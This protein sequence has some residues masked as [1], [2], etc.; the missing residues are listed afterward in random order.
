MAL[1]TFVR[2]LIPVVLLGVGVACSHDAAGLR[3]RVAYPATLRLVPVLPAR[4]AAERA[5]SQAVDSINIAIT[6]DADDTLAIKGVAFPLG[7]DSVVVTI[8]VDLDSAT[9]VVTAQVDIL[10][11][12]QVVYRQVLH[13]TASV[14]SQFS[15]HGDTVPLVSAVWQQVVTQAQ[16]AL[17]GRVGFA[18]VYDA[19]QKE[20]VG[21][22]GATTAGPVGETWVLSGGQWNQLRIAGPAARVGHGMVY[23][24]GRGV[25]VLFGGATASGFTNDTWEFNAAT[26]T[27]IQVTTTGTPS[28]RGAFVL[29]YDVARARIVLFGGYGSAGFLNETW[30]YN[31]ATQTWTQVTTSQAPAARAGS[32]LVYDASLGRSV[33]FGGLDAALNALNDTWTYDGTAWAQVCAACAPPVRAALGMAYD[34]SGKVLLFGGANTHVDISAATSNTGVDT[35]R[36]NDLWAFDGSTWTRLWADNPT[37]GPSKRAGMAVAFDIQNAALVVIS[38]LSAKTLES[39]TWTWNGSAWTP[40]ATAAFPARSQQAMVFDTRRVVAI[41]YGGTA[42]DTVTWLFDGLAWRPVAFGGPGVRSAPAM[43]Y[44]SSHGLVVLFGGSRGGSPLSDTW[45][46][47]GTAW[48]NPETTGAP[49]ARSGA[50]MVFDGLLGKVVMFGG[51]GASATLNDTWQ[52]D[53]GTATWTQV[54]TAASPSARAGAAMTYD[55]AHAKVVLFGGGSGL[56]DTWTYNGTTWT[57]VTTAHAPSA[58]SG[59]ALTYEASR[60]KSVLFGGTASGT[61]QNDLWVF[62]GSDWT[63]LYPVTTPSARSGTAMVRWV[64]GSLLLFGGSASSGDLADTWLFR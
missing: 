48:T 49:P 14:T 54:S 31:G 56:A 30:E 41:M 61:R 11:G 3:P 42:A 2:R 59:A 23:D 62:D 37:S 25:T 29:A 15:P 40:T 44:D 43:A 17:P 36:H 55:A 53:A 4:T 18:T 32:G 57:Q 19:G 58:R 21:F 39:D 13:V 6:N 64:G 24:A 33:L 63:Q 47:D 50:A 7:Q 12:G 60:G 34:P 26:K 20:M 51:Q 45:V 9:Q 10:A 5:T 35:V 27:W 22:G 16:T 28:A 38:G 8:A 52:Y 1:P 46:Y